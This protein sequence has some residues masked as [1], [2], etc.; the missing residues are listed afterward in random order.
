MHRRSLSGKSDGAKHRHADAAVPS[1][2]VAPNLRRLPEERGWGAEIDVNPVERGPGEP[3]LELAWK[4]ATAPDVPFAALIADPAPRGAVA[5]GKQRLAPTH[6]EASEPPSE[7]PSK[8]RFVAEGAL[9][10]AV[11]R[12]PGGGRG[13]LD[14]SSCRSSARLSQSERESG[15]TL[16]CHVSQEP[17]KSKGFPATDALWEVPF[18]M[19]RET[20]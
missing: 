16:S 5:L 3:S 18:G 19:E 13:R 1:A 17:V 9:E 7:E 12:G 15:N 10:V 20:F 8:R 2:R 4:I 14:L 6:R 11:A